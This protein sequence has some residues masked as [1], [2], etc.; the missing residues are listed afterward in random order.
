M[1]AGLISLLSSMSYMELSSRLPTK[2]SCYVFSYHGLGELAG[3]VGAVCLTMEYGISGA[4]VARNWSAKLS[5]AIGYHPVLCHN[6]KPFGQGCDEDHD[7]YYDPIAAVMTLLC[8]WVVARGLNMGKIVINAFTFAKIILVAF[9]IVAGLACWTGNQFDNFAPRGAPGVI[10]ATSLLFFGFIGFDE[11]CCMASKADNPSKTMPR[12]LAGTLIGAALFSGL[13]QFS[14]A[15]MVPYTVG[16]QSIGF[17]EAFA[18]KGLFWARWLVSVGELVLLPLVVL[19]SVL[20]QPEVTAAMSEDGLIPSIFRRKNREGTYVQGT[21][22]CGGILTLVAFAVPFAVLWDVISL[23]VLMSFN[24]TNAALINMRYGNGG[25]LRKPWVDVLVWL[26]MITTCIA[27]FTFNQGILSPLLEEEPVITLSVVFFGL[28]SACALAIMGGIRFG[29]ET[30]CDMDDTSLFKAWGVPFVPGLA[31][32]CNFF[33]LATLPWMTWA[34]F[35]AL[36]IVFFILY[37]AYIVRPTTT[38]V[39]ARSVIEVVMDQSSSPDES[40]GSSATVLA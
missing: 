37:A 25:A 27:G 10:D 34:Y 32:F 3:V 36:L 17:E 15:A 22:L 8:T 33:L 11:V 2:G 18:N 30:R 31:M 29:F 23:G 28:S 19:L 26:L 14:L 4:G 24:L 39:V 7:Y 20:P 21:W 16:M 5:N 1:A 13:A 12:A 9:M 35:S 40:G 6:F 38:K